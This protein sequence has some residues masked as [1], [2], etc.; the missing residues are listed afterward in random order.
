M[1]STLNGSSIHGNNDSPTEFKT[2]S[3]RVLFQKSSGTNRPNGRIDLIVPGG[4]LRRKEPCA[5]TLA[6]YVQ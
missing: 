3:D 6:F 5:S 4:I 1:H 2:D